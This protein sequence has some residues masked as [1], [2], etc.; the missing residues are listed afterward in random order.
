LPPAKEGVARRVSALP[1]IMRS[2]RLIVG[3]SAAD[4]E[5]LSLIVRA[6]SRTDGSVIDG[7]EGSD[8]RSG[9]M[10]AS[11]L[12]MRA[13]PV[14]ERVC[15]LIIGALPLVVRDLLRIRRALPLIFDTLPSA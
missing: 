15:P 5:G 10:R 1:L 11:T 9:M 13:L 6:F 14:I 8:A 4:G 12:I 3:G 2:V 7:A